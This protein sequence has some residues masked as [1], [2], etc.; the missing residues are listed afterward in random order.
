M[1]SVADWSFL[2]GAALEAAMMNDGSRLDLL[3]PLGI[4]VSSA[5]GLH[6]RQSPITQTPVNPPCSQSWLPTTSSTT[7]CTAEAGTA[8]ALGNT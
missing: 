1:E 7:S 8:C 2:G 5:I 4:P 6:H 3:L